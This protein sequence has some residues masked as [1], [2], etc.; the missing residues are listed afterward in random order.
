MRVLAMAPFWMG[1]LLCLVS[2]GYSPATLPPDAIAGRAKIYDYSPSV[3]QSANLQKA[4]WCGYDDNASNRT[5]LS[6]SIQYQA[7]NLATHTRYGP[8]PVLGETLG[9]WDSVFTCNPKV[10]QGSF[11]NPL[12]DG[13]NFVYAMY[14]VGL[15]SVPG[16]NNFIGVAFSNDGIAW[17]KYPRP[18]ISPETSVGYGVGQPALYNDQKHGAIRMFY[19]DDGFYMHHVEAVSTDGVHFTIVG[20]LT[21]NGLDLASA[22]WGD[23]AFDSATDSWYAAF[24]TPTRDPATTGDVWER[25]Q[26]GVQL[27][28][29]PSASLLTG[30]TP[31]QLVANFDTNL[32]GYESNFLAAF[33]RD[34]YGNL[35]T[36]SAIQM[37]VSVSNPP[38]PWDASATAA[39][40]SGDIAYWDISLNEWSPGHPLM[41]LNRYF[42]QKTHQVTTG[43]TDPKGGFFLQAALGHIYQGP[44]GAASVPWYGCKNGSDDYFISLDQGCEGARI[45]G[46]N[47]Y[48]YSEPVTGLHLIALYRCATDHDHFVSADA[49]CE[50]QVSQELLGYVLP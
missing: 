29:I 11:V 44:Q 17:E 21:L 10:I 33:V 34:P 47:G 7:I 25:G 22:S 48:A 43:W 13:K 41:P 6:D 19:E 39:G 2:C 32:S 49:R 36:G 28:R 14:Y 3:I 8:V 20:T 12:G 4:W 42:N 46:V 9:S 15:G 5:Q 35:V 23:M 50:G 16:S 31:W 40:A 45:L 37:Y 18:V 24:N 38:P 1:L 27:Y 30:A 26:Y